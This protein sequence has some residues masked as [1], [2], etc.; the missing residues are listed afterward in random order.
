MMRL[1]FIAR[2]IFLLFAILS[3]SGVYAQ[4]SL[5]IFG[6]VI[7]PGEDFGKVN[8]T[9]TKDSTTVAS[10]KVNENGIFR[11]RLGYDTVYTVRFARKG[12]LSKLLIVDTRIP[13]D[14]DPV[15]Q[16]LVS[17]KLELLEDH[18]GMDREAQPLGKVLYSRITQEFTYETRYQGNRMTNFEV[19][20]T[21]LYYG[22]WDDDRGSGEEEQEMVIEYSDLGERKINQYQE[23]ARKREAFLGEESDSVDLDSDLPPPQTIPEALRFD[24][25]ISRYSRHGM[26]VTEVI[27]NNKHILRVYHLVKHDWGGIFYFKNYRSISKVQFNLETHLNSRKPDETALTS[28]SENS[29]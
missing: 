17:L 4:D 1:P 20:G 29:Q 13:A 11:F 3:A 5:R 28:Q 6:E 18:T 22:D 24:T 10:Y 2:F 9:V 25:T 16:Q 19:S 14:D 7:T 23:I 26:D 27:I 15:L 12:F 21:D 8:I